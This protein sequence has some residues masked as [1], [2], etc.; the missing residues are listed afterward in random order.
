M[1]RGVPPT[2]RPQ[3][4]ADQAFEVGVDSE[5]SIAEAHVRRLAAPAGVSRNQHA[6]A[7]VARPASDDEEVG[8]R[9]GRQGRESASSLKRAPLVPEIA[10]G[11][12]EI[13]REAARDEG[14]QEA[15][16]HRPPLQTLQLADE[17]RKQRRPNERLDCGPGAPSPDLRDPTDHLVGADSLARTG[18]IATREQGA[19]VGLRDQAVADEIRP[20]P[21]EDQIAGPKVTDRSNDNLVARPERGD[22]RA[23]RDPQ[24]HGTQLEEQVVDLA[25]LTEADGAG[26]HVLAGVE[27]LSADDLI[28]IRGSTPEPPGPGNNR[29]DSLEPWSRLEPECQGM[30]R[31]TP[32]RPDVGQADGW[33]VAHARVHLIP[34]YRGDVPDPHGGIRW[35]MPERVRY[36]D[37]GPAAW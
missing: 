15:P 10:P 29:D 37:Q 12:A 13:V 31:D 14:T 26:S 4:I 24:A 7:H 36:W 2:R 32:R 30:S 11:Q 23:T 1:V 8:A 22:H 35:L 16:V 21:E 20:R 34:R 25:Q 17:C 19:V 5:A 18:G 27:S 28:V 3:E 6:P 9:R 33:T